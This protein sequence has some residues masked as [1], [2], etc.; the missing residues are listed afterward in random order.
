MY[1]INI[2]KHRLLTRPDAHEV[3]IKLLAETAC[4]IVRAGGRVGH[5]CQIA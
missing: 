4:A 2:R 1:Y 5:D 3:S